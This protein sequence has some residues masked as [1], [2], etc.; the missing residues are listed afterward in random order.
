MM[1]ILMMLTMLKSLRTTR[2]T[3]TTFL[4]NMHLPGASSLASLSVVP[5]PTMSAVASSSSCVFSTPSNDSA[6]NSS[7]STP[8]DEIEI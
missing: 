6:L 7:P 8:N 3:R 2:T 4:S 1:S 5:D